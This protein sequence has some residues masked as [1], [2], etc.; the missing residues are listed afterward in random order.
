MHIIAVDLFY[1]LYLLSCTDLNRFVRKRIIVVYACTPIYQF[2]LTIHKHNYTYIYILH[3]VI[4]TVMGTFQLLC[5]CLYIYT[6][7]TATLCFV[8]LH[9]IIIQTSAR[10]CLCTRIP[11]VPIILQC[12]HRKIYHIER[13]TLSNLEIRNS[14]HAR[15]NMFSQ[16][17]RTTVRQNTTVRMQALHKNDNIIYGHTRTNSDAHADSIQWH[18]G[19]DTSIIVQLR[20]CMCI[21]NAGN[22]F[23]NLHYRGTMYTTCVI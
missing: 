2:T 14:R 1:F 4:S 5:I 12:I 6:V 16:V 15:E 13:R 19:L 20:V 17:G 9:V 11:N 8:T 21:I 10:P 23:T 22:T 18:T 7:V 3:I